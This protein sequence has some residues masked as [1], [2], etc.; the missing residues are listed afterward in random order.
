MLAFSVRTATAAD[1]GAY[2][3]LCP[4]LGVD[5][6]IATPARFA[7]E[8]APTTLVAVGDSGP[9]LGYAFY[10][11]M[12]SATYVRHVVTAPEA[13]RSGI[14]RA[15]LRAVAERA[16]AAGCESWCLN[17]EPRNA[18]ARALYTSLGFELVYHSQ[19]QRFAWAR[20]E[21]HHP[22]LEEHAW[23]IDESDD[24]AVERAMRLEVGQLAL[25]RAAGGRVLMMLEDADQEVVG[26]AQFDPSFPGAYPFRVARPELAL[27]LLHA[28]RSH[29]RPSDPWIQLCIEGQPEVAALLRDHGAEV[30]FD[31]MH[32]RGHLV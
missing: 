2:A 6:P 28:L 12:Q 1:H 13:R 3:R 30:R 29:A 4:E 31:M 11:V 21:H 7:A 17:V 8:M 23:L 15:L 5:D 18:A 25:A 24:A 9:V 14:A 16:R 27:D 22:P 20:L 26:V 19:V 10:Q 32:L